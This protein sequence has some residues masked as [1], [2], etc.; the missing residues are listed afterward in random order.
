VPSLADAAELLVSGSSAGGLT[1]LLHI[2]VIAERAR[3]VNANIRVS[4]VPEVGFFVDAAS[5]WGGERLYTEV[6]TR[7]ADFGNISAGTPD[8]VNADC[9]A[10]NPGPNRWR[11]FMAQYTYPHIKTPVMI[12]NSKYDQWKRGE[13][14]LTPQEELGRSL[15]FSNRTNCSV[16]HTGFNFSSD[17]FKLNGLFETYADSGRQRI[18]TLFEDKGKFS[19]PSLRNIS[20]TAPYMHDGSLSTLEDVLELYNEG[21]AEFPN[22]DSLIKPLFLS[23]LEKSA[24]LEFLKTLKDE[25]FLKNPAFKQ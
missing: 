18:T 21:G 23:E 15:F 11:C 3:E 13:I 1:T 4:A 24:L 5:I 22:K 12:V 10:A 8:Q 16:C 9:V 19:V 6:Y 20:E 2:D 17:E 14:S 25:S 7:I